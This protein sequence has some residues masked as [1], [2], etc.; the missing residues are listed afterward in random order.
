MPTKVYDYNQSKTKQILR[1]ALRSS[2][3]EATVADLVS[4]TGLPNFQVGQTLNSM[5]DEYRGQL[6]ATESG[7]LIY[8]FPAGFKNR[9]K[10]L[11]PW[12]RRASRAAVR[13]LGIGLTVMF[14]IWIVVMLVGYFVLFI[15]LLLAALFAS[16]AG[17][18]ASRNTRS[19][20]RMGG[21]GTFYLTT[22][23]IQLAIGLWMHSS[24]AK[25]GSTAGYARSRGRGRPLHQSVFAF[26]F[27][28]RDAT[29][30]WET[31][32]KRQAI[33]LIQRSK[34]VITIEEL[35]EITGRDPD[36]ANEMMNEMLREYEG[37]PNVTDDGTIYYQFPS[38]MMTTQG[39]SSPSTY[40]KTKPLIPFN[41][42]PRKTNR[43]IGF[44]NGFNL[45]FGGYFLYWSLAPRITPTDT[46][47]RLY[48][49]SGKY[50]SMIGDPT[51]F[52]FIGLGIIPIAFSIAFYL[53]PLI[54]RGIEK[55]KNEKSRG[56]N[57]RKLIYNSVAQ[58]PEYVLPG[59]IVPTGDS[60]TPRGW[61]KQR[62]SVIDTYAAHK[63]ADIQ[64]EDNR[65]HY[66][67]HELA[68]EQRDIEKL[69]EGIDTD[70]FKIGREVYDSGS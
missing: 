19:R 30:S 13:S 16:I 67:F 14:K 6:K 10:G 34:G 50:L 29:E 70:Q 45:V 58:G 51:G 43:W 4:K 21:F 5:L 48:L 68:R 31:V 2:R 42:N 1:S 8:Y 7:Q 17:T 37:M 47:A 44:L 46:L 59:G 57:L 65:Q 36:G 26:A 54:R 66:V 3:R 22:R 23:L 28:D 12:L 35:M 55:R 41:N 53:V 56:D 69:R 40:M 18:A 63:N 60:E 9:K 52:M 11:L 62:E 38:L 24:I 27:G 15:V 61:E 39:Q 32:Q 33:E 49:I 25:K 64:I 20:S